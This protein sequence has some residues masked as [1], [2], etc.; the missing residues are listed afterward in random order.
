MRTGLAL[1]LF[2]YYLIATSP[3]TSLGPGSIAILGLNLTLSI[4]LFALPLYGMH[5]RLLE[6]KARLMSVVNGRIDGVLTVLH[7][8]LEG[9]EASRIDA[10]N[11]GLSSLLMERDLIA[12][13][14]TW[15][16]PPGTLRVLGGTVL[17]PVALLILARLVEL[18]LAP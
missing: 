10:L 4:L 5:A 11:K 17:L 8:A 9:L 12:R 6:E 18:W 1:I 15:P 3:G 13:A 2:T 14:P 16:W 7:Q